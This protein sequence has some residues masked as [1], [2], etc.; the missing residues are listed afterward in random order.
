M[1]DTRSAMGTVPIPR[2]LWRNSI[3]LIFLCLPIPF[4]IL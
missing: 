4:I 3:P 1:S 2:L